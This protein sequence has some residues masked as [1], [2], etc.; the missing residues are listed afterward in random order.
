Y[1]AELLRTPVGEQELQAGLVAQA[2]VAV[3]AEDRGD[4]EPG[5]DDL[6]GGDPGAEAFGEAGHD[7]QRTADPQVIA[8]AVLGVVD[9]DEGAVVDLVDD[10]LAGVAGDRGLVLARQV[11]QA[12]ISD[13]AAGDL[14][15]RRRRSDELNGGTCGHGRAEG[16]PGQVA[17][18]ARAPQ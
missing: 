6:V 5:V 18:G 10:V 3:V 1:F 13:V 12:R 2:P 8:D 15:D 9:G 7:R 11:R 16:G 17:A 14:L 4:A